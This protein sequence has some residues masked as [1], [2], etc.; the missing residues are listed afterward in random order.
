MTRKPESGPSHRH[1]VKKRS[2]D[3]NQ[4]LHWVVENTLPP[5]LLDKRLSQ[6]SKRRASGAEVDQRYKSRFAGWNVAHVHTKYKSE[7]AGW[8]RYGW[9]KNVLQG[10]GVIPMSL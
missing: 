2:E 8:G 9:L 1:A 5:R 4:S 3:L 10:A 6:I 7:F